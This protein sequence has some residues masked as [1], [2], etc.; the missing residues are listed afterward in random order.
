[1]FCSFSADGNA[2]RIRHR[3]CRICILL[4]VSSSRCH[5]RS[6]SHRHP[7][8]QNNSGFRRRSR[9]FCRCHYNLT[10]VQLPESTLKSGSSSSLILR[11]TPLVSRRLLIFL[12]EIL[13]RLHNHICRHVVT[14]PFLPQFSRCARRVLYFFCR[15]KYQD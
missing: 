8:S 1:M 3:H 13:C 6:R 11:L 9:L 15:N 12:G 5:R 7:L 4:F 14:I 2:Y 10:E